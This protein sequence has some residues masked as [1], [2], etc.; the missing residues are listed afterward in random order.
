MKVLGK[1]ERNEGKAKFF[2]GSLQ[3]EGVVVI[4]LLIK[5]VFSVWIIAGHVVLASYVL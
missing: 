4:S 5:I 1:R 2:S 3:V